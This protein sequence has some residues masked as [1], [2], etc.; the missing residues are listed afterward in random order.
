MNCIY[1]PVLPVL[2]VMYNSNPCR[3]YFFHCICV[4]HT[5]N[6]VLSL[7]VR[8]VRVYPW[9][10][11]RP[12]LITELHCLLH[13]VRSDQWKM[14]C[15]TRRRNQSRTRKGTC[16]TCPARLIPSF[17]V[18]PTEYAF[19]I[20]CHRLLISSMFYMV[21]SSPTLSPNSYLNSFCI[22]HMNHLQHVRR[23]DTFSINVWLPKLS[24]PE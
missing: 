8:S 24:W 16:I 19:Y 9:L 1:R 18:S 7:R 21:S 14:Y 10:V 15:R 20:Y 17:N 3:R 12:L 5:M 23:S 6:V 13:P 11:I 4:K 2:S 22:Y